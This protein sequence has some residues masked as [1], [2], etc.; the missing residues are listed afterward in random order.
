[1]DTNFIRFRGCLNALTPPS[2]PP[3]SILVLAELPFGV[4]LEDWLGDQV[5]EGVGCVKVLVG[6][7]EMTMAMGMRRECRVG[8]SSWLLWAHSAARAVGG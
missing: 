5:W 1:M 2:S 4:L 6:W 7:M 3:S 8:W